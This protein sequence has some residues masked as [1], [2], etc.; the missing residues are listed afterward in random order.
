VQADHFHSRQSERLDLY[1][2]YAGK[3]LEVSRIESRLMAIL[4]RT[5]RLA[6]LTDAFVHPMYSRRHVKNWPEQAQ[7][8]HTTD[9]ACI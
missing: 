1:K 9:V 4:L 3:L 7:A 6:M 8:R 2:Q 5:F